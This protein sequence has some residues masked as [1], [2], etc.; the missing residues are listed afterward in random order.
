MAI[1]E[2]YAYGGQKNPAFT[3][4]DRAFAQRDINLYYI[5]GDPLLKSLVSDARY[6]AFLR[7]MNLPE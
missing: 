3:W 7:K 1:A 2:A 5:K 6:K 4:L